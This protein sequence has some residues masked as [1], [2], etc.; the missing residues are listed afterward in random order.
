MLATTAF[1]ASCEFVVWTI[2]SL[3]GLAV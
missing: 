2:P 3:Y 1:A